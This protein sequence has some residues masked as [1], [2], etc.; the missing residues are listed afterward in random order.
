LY[1]PKKLG[2]KLEEKAEK[3]G[4]TPEE[5]CLEI[6]GKSLDEELDPAQLVEHYQA[7]SERYLGEAKNFLEEED[8]V[9]A[10]EK[11]WGA[12]ALI[13]RSVAAKR[14]LKLEKHGSLWSFIDKLSAENRDEEIVRFFA[15][16][17]G[18]H[19]NFYENQMTRRTVEIALKDVER[20]IKKLRNLE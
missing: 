13:V 7:L 11:L 19:R 8:L 14:G 18:L 20:F 6:L 12:A 2:A 1:Y 3:V 15:V 16:A 5:L 4:V 10:S 9:Q 17:N